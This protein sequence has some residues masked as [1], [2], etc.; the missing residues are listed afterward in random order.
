MI[1]RLYEWLIRS[2]P[3][4]FRQR[5]GEQMLSIFDDSTGAKSG[6]HLLTDAFVSLLRQRL[7]RTERSRAEQLQKNTSRV[8]L[9]WTV[10]ALGWYVAIT[11]NDPFVLRKTDPHR[12]QD[13][14]RAKGCF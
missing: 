1:R 14:A 4:H 10:G 9:A 13:L 5:F 2:H 12:E 6:L 11:K 8:N 3:D 7:L